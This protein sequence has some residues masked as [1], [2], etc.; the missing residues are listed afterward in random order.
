MDSLAPPCDI[1]APGGRPR[2]TTE[3]MSWGSD[4]AV[5]QR[6]G[7]N[8]RAAREQAGVSQ[9]ALAHASHYHRTYIADIERGARNASSVVLI[10]L[11]YHLGI[12]T[13]RLFDGT[14]DL[15]D[16]V[17]PPRGSAGS[18]PDVAHGTG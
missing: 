13:N 7:E 15:I 14:R 17:R 18:P 12:D 1:V 6:I 10:R 8:L 4:E 5:I 3:G 2:G 11:A 9:T 16:P